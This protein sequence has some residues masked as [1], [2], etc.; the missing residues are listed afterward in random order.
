VG[1]GVL[2]LNF[3]EGENADTLGLNGQETFD[4]I[5]LDNGEAKQVEVIAR[6]DNG[7]ETHFKARV[8]LDTPKEVDYYRNGGILHYVLRQLASKPKQAPSLVA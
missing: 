1:M 6:D 5:G 3:I 7:K 2:P 8:R 4:I